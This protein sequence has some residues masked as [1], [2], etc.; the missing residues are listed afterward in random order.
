MTR[1]SLETLVSALRTTDARFPWVGPTDDEADA[2]EVIEAI[3]QE[4]EGSADEPDADGRWGWCI[5]CGERWPC[6]AWVYAERLGV[7]FIG[8]AAARVWA[9]ARSVIDGLRK[10]SAA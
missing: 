8:S 2:A 7:Q 5:G 1:P 6:S 9:H 4:H 3:A 10:G